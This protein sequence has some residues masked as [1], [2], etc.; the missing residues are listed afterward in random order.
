MSL[1]DNDWWLPFVSRLQEESLESLCLEFGLIEEAV[2]PELIEES[3]TRPII[4][5]AWWPEAL[6]LIAA[7]RNPKA[8]A[9]RFGT[10]T[11]RLRKGLARSGV[12]ASGEAPELHTEAPEA[13]SMRPSRSIS[14]RHTGGGASRA[15]GA[16]ELPPDADGVMDSVSTLQR[17]GPRKGRSAE[18]RRPLAA[19]GLPPLT[20]DTAAEPPGRRRRR[21]R[22]RLVRPDELEERTLEPA[23]PR[24]SPRKPK[25]SPHSEVRVIAPDTLDLS[26][27][28]SAPEETAEPAPKLAVLAAPVSEAPTHQVAPKPDDSSHAPPTSA[29]PTSAPLSEPA[30]VAVA[31]IVAQAPVARPPARP[32]PPKAVAPKAAPAMSGGMAWRIRIDGSDHAMV[33]IAGDILQATDLFAEQLG[34]AALRN[35]DIY[36]TPLL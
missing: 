24:R 30:A 6:R 25:S 31:P 32:K 26:E 36:S 21:G 2:I 12:R 35:A 4:E 18:T 3:G 29:P 1:K 15:G 11:R 8:V 9:R 10:H 27:L 7:G 13:A 22:L 17:P 16:D 19:N 14:G 5:S 28:I 34:R 23:S 33:V 20:D